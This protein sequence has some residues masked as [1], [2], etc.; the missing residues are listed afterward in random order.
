MTTRRKFQTKAELT[1]VGW[2]IAGCPPRLLN[3]MFEVSRDQ[4]QVSWMAIFETSYVVSGDGFRLEGWVRKNRNSGKH[5]GS[6]FDVKGE[7]AFVEHCVAWAE[8]TRARFCHSIIAD[9]AE[10]LPPHRREKVA[11]LVR[12]AQ[13]ARSQAPAEVG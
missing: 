12:Q 8:I 2:F 5:R 9:W 13:E 6:G 11:A 4:R 10:R 1:K 3:D 7:D